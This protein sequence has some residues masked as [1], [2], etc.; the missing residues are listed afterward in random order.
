MPIQLFKK[1][2]S[3]RAHNAIDGVI[4][5]VVDY[6]LNYELNYG[7]ERLFSY[8][9]KQAP[10]PQSKDAPQAA[11]MEVDAPTQ[12]SAKPPAQTHAQAPDGG[13]T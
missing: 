10:Q 5:R 9:A 4:K 11:P 6:E 2:V 13:E 7:Q 1:G 8:F 3:K 12:P